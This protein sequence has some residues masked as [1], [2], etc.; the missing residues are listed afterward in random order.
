MPSPNR[1]PRP[2]PS[3]RQN[4]AKR[5]VDFRW[6]RFKSRLRLL[7][8]WWLWPHATFQPLFVIATWR[9]GS[10]LLLSYLQQQPTLAMLSE[11][12]CSRLTIGLSHDRSSPY[13]A[14]QHIRF[15]LQGERAPIRGC[16]LMLH[17]LSNCDL[18]LDDLNREFPTAKYIVLYRQALAE[19]FVSH[20]IAEATEQYLLHK[21]E[22]PREAE[23]HVDPQE[24][25]AYCDDIRRRYRNVVECQWLEGKA[26]LLS[27]E[28]LVADPDHWLKQH[29]CPMLNVPFGGSQTKLVKQSKRPLAEQI[30]NYHEVAALVNSPL[31]RQQH[32][33]SWRQAGRQAA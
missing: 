15:C 30:I 14:I 5:Q 25:R 29:F 8:K 2:S 27:Y 4:P 7:Q 26:T 9:S 31:C 21:G 10:N 3:L 19:Q 28:E 32:S 23:I 20:R 6:A 11:V 24:L 16:K 22:T 13:Q 1:D 33:W 18:S 17:Q 12:L